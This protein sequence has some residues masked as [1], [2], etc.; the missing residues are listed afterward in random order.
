[1]K[2]LW[3][4]FNFLHPTTKGGQIRTL[5]M[6]R[7]LH[8]RH[9]IHYVACEN[10]EEPEGLERAGEYSTRAF[11]VSG[12][13]LDKGSP[14]FLLELC[15]GL[16]SSIPVAIRRFH[17]PEIGR[18]LSESR[19]YDRAVCDFL[20][21]ARYFPNLRNVTLFQHNVETLIWRRRA[22]Q[23]TD[24]LRRAYI[25][26]QARKM[27]TYERDV[28]RA[29]GSVL[30]VSNEDA[31]LMREM[32]GVEKVS[33]V[34]TGV[35][36]DHFAPAAG[37][38][39]GSGLVF[40]GSMDWAPNIDGIEWF[41]REILPRIR[42]RRECSLTIAG[43]S[44]TAEVQELVRRNAN[45]TLTGTVPDIRPFLW[46]AAVSVVPLRIGGGTRLKIYE[47]M[48]ARVPVV[49]TSIGAE[50]LPV[51]DREHLLI[52]DTPEAFAEGCLKLL[53]DADERRRIAEAAWK[54]VAEFCSWDSVARHFEKLLEQGPNWR[55]ARF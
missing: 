34:P 48:A 33:A 20:I 26:H 15:A 25:A 45:V 22:E 19:D 4:N 51:R 38:A 41:I 18:L 17:S 40:V 50:G 47:S 29:C 1:M 30:A 36:I 52:A 54:F 43:R 32:F 42:A 10:P 13:V 39:S 46:K 7:Q 14:L 2:I 44:P 9:E 53:D 35:D 3:V 31:Q 12:R 49:S 21:P 24:P 16:F 37:I 11:P 27:F 55:S 6:L 28:C 5:E 8:R 23:A